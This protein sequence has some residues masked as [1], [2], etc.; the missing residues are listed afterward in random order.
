MPKIDGP[1]RSL[2]RRELYNG[3]RYVNIAL[4]SGPPKNFLEVFCAVG[5]GNLILQFTVRLGSDTL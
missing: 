2:G 1:V 4:V 3:L 5:F